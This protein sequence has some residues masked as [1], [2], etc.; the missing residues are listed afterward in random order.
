[1]SDIQKR[2]QRLRKAGRLK[3]PIRPAATVADRPDRVP[4]PEAAR[5]F[6]SPSDQAPA[7][8][9][10]LLDLPGVEEVRTSRGRFLLRTVR[11][12]LEHVQGTTRLGAV[13]ELPHQAA[14]VA[15]RDP[16]LAP[17]DFRRVLFLD[18]ETS[19]LAGGA[20][21]I[22]FLTG[23]GGFEGDH[24]V[25][26][27]YFARNPAEEPA[28]LPHL[29]EQLARAEGVVTFN[30]KAF[31]MPL[32]RSRFILAGVPLA[33]ERLPHLDLLHPA[34][35]LW[36]ARLGAC[37]FG[38]LETHILGHQR[39]TLDAPSWLIPTLWFRFAR[40]E[41]AANDMARILYHNLEDVVSMAPLAH[42]LCGVYDGELEPHPGDA[43]SLARSYAG[44]GMLAQA[45]AMY[46]RA[47]DENLGHS[48]RISAMKEL[49]QVLKRQKRRDE[50]AF[51][52]EQLAAMNLAGDVEP[53]V[54]L[55]KYHEWETHDL[56][57]ALDWTQEAIRRIQTQRP[58]SLQAHQLAELEHRLKR[59][60]RKLRP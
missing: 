47:L 8:L 46:R 48:Q 3:R 4:A 29:A 25:V 17:F 2:L 11:Y 5:S 59:V 14:A 35:R 7:T 10:D 38:H 40:G 27:Q 53:L 15:A 55:A 51:W 52:W 33:T 23:V 21:T 26:R 6:G 54:E 1:M 45:E 50:A 49:A 20:G 37:N 58:A 41:G 31:D 18:T 12:E 19:G 57:A 30:G 16:D 28:Y 24:Y 42:A 32:L 36:R 34:R 44:Q 9:N 13:L 22:V 43:L 56:E 39:S 60:R